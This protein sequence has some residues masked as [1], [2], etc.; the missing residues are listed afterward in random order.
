M[1][2]QLDAGRE[3][4]AR[5]SLASRL[6]RLVLMAETGPEGVEAHKASLF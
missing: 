1:A 3:K 6:V 5:P 4:T 2:D